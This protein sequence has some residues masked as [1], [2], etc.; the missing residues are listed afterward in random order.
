MRWERVLTV[1]GVHAEGEVGK[2]VTGG[3]V[4]VPGKTMF[5]KMLHLRDHDDG[6]RKF[7]LYEPRGA[8]V[9]SANLVLPSN[10]P[11]A[12]LGFI[13]MESVEYPPM[14]GSNTICTVTAILET[15]ILPMRGPVVDLT[16]ETPAGLIGVS[17]RCRGGK[18]LQVKFQNVPAFVHY[19]G[20]PVEVEGVGTVTIDVAYGGMN[21]ALVDAGVFG[22]ALRPDEAR[23]ICALGQKIKAAATAQL[24][25]VHPEN[26]KIRDVTV[27]E[28][29]GP[30][31]RRGNRLTARN[32]V[33]VSP[34]RLDRSP[35]GTGTCARLAVMHARKQIRPGEVFD[36]QSIIGTHF[37]SEIVR[38]TRIGSKRAVVPT[39]AGRAW[40]TSIGQYG[41][42]PDDPFP[43]GY[44]LSDT[45]MQ[46]I[47]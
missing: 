33:V 24:K 12:A 47:S 21:Y 7:L 39:V 9:H 11:K 32:T 10:H 1:V 35:C 26:P 3:V 46:A 41:Y 14:S 15:G 8:A 20:A 37:I 27:T 16:L 42:D 43:H 38:T 40:I 5:D 45:W 31:S 44:T 23:D 30:V 22:L 4:D 29:M 17:C 28:F 19:L 18:V 13:I 2:V 25:V 6:L 34:G 36:H